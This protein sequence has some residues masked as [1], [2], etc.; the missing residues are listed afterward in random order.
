[1]PR[2]QRSP[3]TRSRSSLFSLLLFPAW[4]HAELPW[5]PSGVPV[6]S[7]WGP[8]GVPVDLPDPSSGTAAFGLK[9]SASSCKPGCGPSKMADEKHEK[10]YGKIWKKNGKSNLTISLELG[11]SSIARLH[12]ILPLCLVLQVSASWATWQFELQGS[13]PGLACPRRSSLPRDQHLNPWS[14]NRALWCDLCVYLVPTRRWRTSATYCNMLFKIKS[15]IQ[16]NTQQEAQSSRVVSDFSIDS[17]FPF[18]IYNASKLG[19]I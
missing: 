16:T 7:Q 19:Q 14:D 15:H 11:P 13:A 12:D 1:M 3:A 17:S 10:T 9:G 2:S 5:G 6:A 18:Q 4:R 8:S